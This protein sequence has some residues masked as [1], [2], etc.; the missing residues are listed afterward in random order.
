MG[1][2]AKDPEAFPD[3]T[4]RP[5]QGISFAVERR[6]ADVAIVEGFSA[7]LTERLVEA[8]FSGKE[9]GEGA[10]RAQVTRLLGRDGPTHHGPRAG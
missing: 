6:G 2:D 5:S 7:D 3:S 4:R 8:A 9:N 10:G 1:K